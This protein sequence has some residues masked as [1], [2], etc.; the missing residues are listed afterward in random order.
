MGVKKLTNTN[1]ILIPNILK[2]IA[3]LKVLRRKRLS[4]WIDE[5]DGT[6][7]YVFYEKVKLAVE[8]KKA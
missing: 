4:S 3:D 2:E 6:D 5:S 7:L 1:P 8:E